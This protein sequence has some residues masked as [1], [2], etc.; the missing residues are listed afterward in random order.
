MTPE[1]AAVTGF[2]EIRSKIVGFEGPVTICGEVKL[3][4]FW[5][6]PEVY[7]LSY[8]VQV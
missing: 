3:V 4:F 8:V 1:L 6:Y 5:F 7:S 2:E